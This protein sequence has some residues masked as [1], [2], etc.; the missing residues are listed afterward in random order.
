MRRLKSCLPVQRRIGLMMAGGGSSN[1]HSTSSTA[2]ASAGAAAA[3][4]T[5]PSRGNDGYSVALASKNPEY[6]KDV[7][8]R[9]MFLRSEHFDAAAAAR[10]LRHFLTMKLELFGPE[11][12]CRP[13]TLDDL[14]P[15]DIECLMNGHLQ[16]LN[17]RDQAGRDVVVMAANHIR[18]KSIEN[19]VR[20]SLGTRRRM[21]SDSFILLFH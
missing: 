2:D 3:M 8:F 10:K 17:K 14:D 12:L 7:K 4:M 11:K 21:C 9:L 19:E 5:S 13:I 1:H 20:R 18:Y 15:D 16:L 6:V